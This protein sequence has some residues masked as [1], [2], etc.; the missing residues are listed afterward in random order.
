MSDH[1]EPEQLFNALRP[2][3]FSIAYRMLSIRADAEDV[4]QD[5]WLRWHGTGKDEITSMEAWLVT[6]RLKQVH[7]D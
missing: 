3:L 5:S 1:T 6:T 2:R 7:V 4:V